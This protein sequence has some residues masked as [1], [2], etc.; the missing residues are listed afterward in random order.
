MK[1]KSDKDTDV[2]VEELLVL[3]RMPRERVLIETLW[4]DLR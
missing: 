4:R 3:G 2:G 1:E